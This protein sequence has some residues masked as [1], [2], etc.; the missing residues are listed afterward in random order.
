VYLGKSKRA[1]HT[2]L[3]LVIAVIISACSIASRAAATSS[4]T[5]FYVSPAGNDSWS[6]TSRS[7]PFATVGGAQNAIRSL[8]ANGLSQ[9]VTVY[10][11]GGT[12]NL[13]TPVVFTPEDS[14]TSAAPITYA[15]YPSQQ[16][17]ISGGQQITG[18]SPYTGTNIPAAAQ[19]KVWSA[20]V[21]GGGGWEF[22]QLFVN[23]N[24][25]IRA[26][27]PNAGSFY[28]AEGMTSSWPAPEQ[29]FYASGDILPQWA[30]EPD[31]EVVMLQ[32]WGDYRSVITSV[33]STLNS[34]TLDGTYGPAGLEQN[35][36]YWV[37]NA[38]EA[39]DSPGEWYLDVPNS[40]VYYYP[41]PGENMQ[42]AQVIAPVID[43]L[44]IF[45]GNASSGSLVS[46]ITLSGLTLAYADWALP[47]NFHAEQASYDIPAVVSGAGA[48]S[49]AVQQCL[50]THIGDYAVE[51]SQGSQNNT[52][53]GNIITDV[54]AGG[55]KIGDPTVPATTQT[56]TVNNAVTDNQISN[57][58][59]VYPSAVGIWIGESSGNDIA[60]NQINNTYYSGISVGWTWG[61]GASAA[62]NNI[63]EQNDI[64]D[65]GQGMLSDMG[66][67]YTLGIQ[68]GTSVLNNICHDVWRNN[69]STGYGGWGLYNDAG[70]SNIVMKDN[71][72]YSTQDGGFMTNYGQG[73]NIQNNIFAFG[74]TAQLY[75]GVPLPG[76][77][78]SFSFTNNIVY[79]NQG[80]V[81]AGYWLDLGFT[82]DY[83]DYNCAGCNS[84]FEPTFQWWQTL[85]QDVHSIV[86][87]PLF[88]NASADNFSLEPDSPAFGLGFVAPDFSQVGPRPEMLRAAIRLKRRMKPKAR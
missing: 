49:C 75:R 73:N 34:V 78:Q 76:T 40:R 30:Q 65:I 12:Y 8:K 56:E 22:R 20:Q 81:L 13:T 80:Q 32:D 36:R 54:G 23:G 63:I 26:R 47:G 44:F 86:A 33:T 58:G 68:P 7:T 21:A 27:S 39:L 5:T 42:T 60:H 69:A 79:W 57:I 84:Q 31:V 17:I 51:F 70:S 82:M 3:P 11:L 71:L 16:P 14:G 53:V 45:Q 28:N 35:P 4:A 43:Q 6:G 59:L 64:F 9:P 66:C 2:I 72:V 24:R 48:S 74:E 55:I 67:V 52:V 62:Q 77:E 1:R 38:I 46:N 88:V 87:D 41:M 61:Y 37:E 85:G 10:L 18:W 50:F 83:N 29:F 25:R 15:A 19:G